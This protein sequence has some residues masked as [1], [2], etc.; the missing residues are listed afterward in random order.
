MSTSLNYIPYGP[1]QQT[2]DEAIWYTLA[3]HRIKL[4]EWLYGMIVSGELVPYEYE[5]MVTV[6]CK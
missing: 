1:Y 3:L 5:G 6:E 4:Q 2:P